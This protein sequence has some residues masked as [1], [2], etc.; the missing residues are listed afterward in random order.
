[1]QKRTFPKG[2]RRNNDTH[3]VLTF[4]SLNWAL[5]MPKSRKKFTELRRPKTMRNLCE[6]WTWDPEGAGNGH[7]E[8]KRTPWTESHDML[9]C[10]ISRATW[11]VSPLQL[12]PN[13][14]RMGWSFLTPPPN[15]HL[16]EM[17]SAWDRGIGSY[18][19][20]EGWIGMGSGRGSI[21]LYQSNEHRKCCLDQ[22]TKCPSCM[23]FP[24]VLSASNS[25]PTCNY[26]PTSFLTP[27]Q[28][29]CRTGGSDDSEDEKGEKRGEEKYMSHL[30]WFFVPQLKHVL[31]FNY[32]SPICWHQY[33]VPWLHTS[34][35]SDSVPLAWQILYNSVQRLGKS[36]IT[37]IS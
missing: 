37:L 16:L 19:E 30:P 26:L 1:M 33:K 24:F 20:G 9:A 21:P 15:K 25:L 23:S 8:Q 17:H 31:K 12:G 36:I 18:P 4:S 10:W 3:R 34:H 35:V 5:E 29:Q 14:Y 28:R 13:N 11:E 32:R 2:V 27:H 6:A 7:R 22:K